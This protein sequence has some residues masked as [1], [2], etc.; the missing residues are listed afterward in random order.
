VHELGDVLWQDL[1]EGSVKHALKGKHYKRGLRCL[2][3]MYEAL[4]SQ[5]VKV[6]LT[7]NLAEGTRE[8][9]VILKNTSLSAESRAAAHTAADWRRILTLRASLQS[10][11]SGKGQ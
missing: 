2:K 4:M 5:L 9:L 11:L 6:K 7:P 1:A 10:V 3:L 8:N